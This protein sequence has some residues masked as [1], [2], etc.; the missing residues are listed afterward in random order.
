MHLKLSTLEYWRL[1]GDVIEVFKIT[2]NIYNSIS[3][4][5]VLSKVLILE[6]ININYLITCFTTVHENS[7]SVLV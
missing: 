3:Q 2:H 7:L 6:V 5:H 4:S 1:H